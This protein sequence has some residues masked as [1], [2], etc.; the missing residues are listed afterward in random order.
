LLLGDSSSFCMCY[1]GDG[2]LPLSNQEE[3]DE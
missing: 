3:G 1:I 2:P